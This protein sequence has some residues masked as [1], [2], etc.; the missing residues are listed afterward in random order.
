MVGAAPEC[1]MPAFT[2]IEKKCGTVRKGGQV[3][4]DLQRIDDYKKKNVT[5]KELCLNCPANG[6]PRH[7]RSSPR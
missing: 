4:A 3:A 7:S 6:P 5:F 1:P 2:E